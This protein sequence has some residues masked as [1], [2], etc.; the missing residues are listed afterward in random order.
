MTLP[1]PSGSRNSMRRGAA[2]FRRRRLRRTHRQVADRA[3]LLQRLLQRGL[4]PLE[5][6]EALL[7]PLEGLAQLVLAEAVEVARSP[8]VGLVRHPRRS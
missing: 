6:H 2:R 1:E 4:Q 8:L 3:L 7:D 5:A